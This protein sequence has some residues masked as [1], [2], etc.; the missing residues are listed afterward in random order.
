MS[1]YKDDI[2]WLMKGDCLE[3]MKELM[4]EVLKGGNMDLWGK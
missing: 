3:R 1:D 2:V 4:L